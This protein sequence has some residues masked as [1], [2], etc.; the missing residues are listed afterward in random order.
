MTH[1]T[2]VRVLAPCRPPD[3]DVVLRSVTVG[4]AEHLLPAAVSWAAVQIR[5]AN[6]DEF[7]EF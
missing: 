1:T 4:E 6:S 5:A 3:A 2:R 7:S